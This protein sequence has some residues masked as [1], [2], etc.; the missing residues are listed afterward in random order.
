MVSMR[1]LERTLRFKV[2]D[3]LDKSRR[4]KYQRMIVQYPYATR[5][6]FC[7]SCGVR[8]PYGVQTCSYCGAPQRII[9][10]SPESNMSNVAPQGSD[11][12]VLEY[13]VAHNGTI[14][15]SQAANEL[16]MSHEALRLTIDRLKSAGL[17]KST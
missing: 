1:N 2:E 10:A 6:Q 16:S 7:D 5:Q 13:I 8:I 11:Q 17:L 3:L 14:S 15:M 4:E 12:R 9:Q